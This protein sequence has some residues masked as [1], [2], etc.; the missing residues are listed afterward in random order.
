MPNDQHRQR[1][2]ALRI[3]NVGEAS[4]VATEPCAVSRTG[5]ITP[6]TCGMYSA[7]HVR[8]WAAI[9]D[10]MH[11]DMSAKLALALVHAGRRGSTRPRREGIDRPLRQG[12]WEL[13]SA[14]A[15]ALQPAESD[16]RGKSTSTRWRGCE[17]NSLTLRA[18]E[19]KPDL[20]QLCCIALTVICWGASCRRWATGWADSY[21][22]IDRKS[23]AL[24]AG[25]VR[26]GSRSV[27]R[28]Q[29]GF[30][31]HPCFGLGQGWV[32]TG[33]RRSSDPTARKKKA[34]IWR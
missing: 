33:T 9:V 34:V 31:S 28:P 24:S 15:I 8:A 7:E 17:V 29:T 16:S 6:G 20:T 14:S 27:A 12:Q 30:C 25:G 1:L 22:D 4:L 26:C 5:R 21:G 19:R 2:Q 11:R 3:A 18:K 13:V 32:G 23:N 10:G